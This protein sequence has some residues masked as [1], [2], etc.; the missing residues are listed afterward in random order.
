MVTAVYVIDLIE[1]RDPALF[2]V[3]ID[4]YALMTTY[5]GGI[6]LLFTLR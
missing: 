2:G 4:S 1:R 3:G 6:A 5:V